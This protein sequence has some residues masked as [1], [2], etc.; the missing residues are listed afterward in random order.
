[1]IL[2]TLSAIKSRIGLGEE[3]VQDDAVLTNLLSLVSGWF[4]LDTNRSFEYSA[5]ATEEFPANETE[6]ACAR[7]PI[8][9]SVAAT[10]KL[11][12]NNT[13]GWVSQ[14]GVSYVVRRACVLSLSSPLGGASGQG[15]AIYAGGYILPGGSAVEGVDSLPAEI[16]QAIIEQV[17]SMYRNRDRFGVESVSAQGGS[18]AVARPDWLPFAQ[19]M[20]DK[21]RRWT[22]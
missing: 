12:L 21:Y 14:T 9:V 6:I 20:V 13:D 22:L 17:V 18:L 16:E 4:E 8:N 10:F 7:Y 19:A 5:A 15:Q 3:D 1:M 2:T 11:L